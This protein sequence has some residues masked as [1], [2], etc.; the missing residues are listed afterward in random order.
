MII[1]ISLFYEIHTNNS[2][3]T[4][5]SLPIVAFF[6][7][8][9]QKQIEDIKLLKYVYIIL[10]FYSWFR[11]FQFNIIISLLNILFIFVI[12]IFFN[13]KKKIYSLIKTY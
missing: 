1:L 11:L 7:Y 9:I 2:A 4:F 10:I 3:M 12:I 6:L 8:Q 5:I 13:S